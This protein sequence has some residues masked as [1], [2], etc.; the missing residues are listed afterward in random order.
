MSPRAGD[1][2]ARLAI[3][4]VLSAL[5]SCAIVAAVPLLS[6]SF[7]SGSGGQ[8]DT[9]VIKYSEVRSSNSVSTPDSTRAAEGAYDLVVGL[10]H[11]KTGE[12]NDSLSTPLWRLMS[13]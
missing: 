8:Q 9:I 4:P 3:S 6:R 5:L 1:R 2:K 11:H 13:K 12:L 7:I 10:T